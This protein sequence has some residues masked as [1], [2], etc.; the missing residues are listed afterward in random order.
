V[1]RLAWDVDRPEAALLVQDA[2]VPVARVLVPAQD[3]ARAL[4]SGADDL[5]EARYRHRLAKVAA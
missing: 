1:Y 5:E 4:I 3:L 2:V